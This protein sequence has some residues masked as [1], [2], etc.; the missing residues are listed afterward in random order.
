MNTLKN[1]LNGESGYEKMRNRKNFEYFQL[2]QKNLVQLTRL[3]D[4]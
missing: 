4:H 1:D 3:Y 2:I